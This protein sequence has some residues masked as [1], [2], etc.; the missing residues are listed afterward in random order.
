M[1]THTFTVTHTLSLGHKHPDFAHSQ[2]NSC[3]TH[4]HMDTDGHGNAETPVPLGDT[5]EIL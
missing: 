1:Q 5:D 3:P 4:T 2:G